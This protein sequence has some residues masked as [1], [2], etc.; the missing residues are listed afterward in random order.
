MN[1]TETLAPARLDPDMNGMPMTPEE[2]DAVEDWN[3]D[4]R[5]E[6]VRGVLIVV[7][8]P[9]AGERTPND[10]LG[11][12]FRVYRDSHP[13]GSSLDDTTFEQTIRTSTG[14]R[15]ADRVV[16][17]GLGRKPNYRKDIP[18]IAIEFV[19]RRK[20]DWKRDHLEKRDEY[21]E[22]GVSEYWVIDRFRR[23]MTV[24][25]GLGEELVIAE[26]DVYR[27]DLLLGFELPLARILAIA[28]RCADAE[29]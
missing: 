26:G 4:Y 17:A 9:S 12:L 10:E 14:R 21:A 3:E 27:T 8:P 6:L 23:R 22:A 24:Y 25:R 7:P 19:A 29:S 15:I 16:W 13:Q 20:R 28:D 2:F 18:T 5:Y 1:A 11:Y